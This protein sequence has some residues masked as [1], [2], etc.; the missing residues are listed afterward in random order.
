[1]HQPFLRRYSTPSRKSRVSCQK[2]GGLLDIKYDW[3]KL[4]RIKSLSFFEGRWSTKGV[5][6]EGQLDFSGVW[7]FRELAP[8]LP[9]R[10]GYRQYHRRR[11]HPFSNRPTCSA[12]NWG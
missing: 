6:V 12:I 10:T 3:D 7:R 9:D 8:L 1:M 4:P 2:C 5:G 11:P